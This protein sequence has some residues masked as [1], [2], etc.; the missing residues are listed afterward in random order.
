MPESQQDS[1]PSESTESTEPAAQEIRKE[2]PVEQPPVARTSLPLVSSA[3]EPSPLPHKTQSRSDEPRSNLDRLPAAGAVSMPHLPTAESSALSPKTA[4]VVPQLRLPRP[5]PQTPPPGSTASLKKEEGKKKELRL[6]GKLVRRRATTERNAKEAFPGMATKTV[7]DCVACGKS[8]DTSGHLKCSTCK[9]ETCASCTVLRSIEGKQRLACASCGARAA[10][11][12]ALRA[13][14][15][16]APAAKGPAG[17]LAL[18][19]TELCAAE[20]AADK[21]P[22]LLDFLTAEVVAKG[23]RLTEGIFRLSVSGQTLADAA[24]HLQS[25]TAGKYSLPPGD[26]HCAG[27]LLKQ[28]L[29]DL[30]EP[31]LCD[32]EAAVPPWPP[33]AKS[34]PEAGRLLDAAVFDGAE[35]YQR[36]LGKVL[37]P[38]NARALVRLGRFLLSMAEP[39]AVAKTKMGAD[40]L[41]TVFSQCIMRNPS[42]D[43]FA[44]LKNQPREHRFLASF[45]RHLAAG[46]FDAPTAE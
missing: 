43:P 6:S 28:W 4:P 30:P 7:A 13:K 31:L 44:L 14:P 22:L 19:L 10:R 32:Y 3:A 46:A 1:E 9:R 45:L 15:T 23:G 24:L 5:L 34:D 36:L 40:N 35:H 41:C 11:D 38:A 17:L 29:R 18:S 39:E 2:D 26:V 16:K 8:S 27:A 21:G 42:S 25:C 12:A 33:E 37:P 20:G